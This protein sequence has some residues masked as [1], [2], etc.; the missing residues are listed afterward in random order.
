MGLRGRGIF[1]FSSFLTMFRACIFYVFQHQLEPF[2]LFRLYSISRLSCVFL[3]LFMLSRSVLIVI[4]VL[5]CSVP[6]YRLNVFGIYS[7]PIKAVCPTPSKRTPRAVQAVTPFTPL[8]KRRG[9]APAPAW[10]FEWRSCLSLTSSQYF[11][12]L[13]RLGFFGSLFI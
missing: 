12:S 11:G 6:F 10:P 8:Q 3:F 5:L 4:I 9:L 1:T 7:S 13:I 2:F